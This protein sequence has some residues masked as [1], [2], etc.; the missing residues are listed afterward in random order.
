MRK[1]NKLFKS[2]V[3]CMATFILLALFIVPQLASAVYNAFLSISLTSST[4]SQNYGWC[5][6]DGVDKKVT[7]MQDVEFDA[8][9]GMDFSSGSWTLD[10]NGKLI[11]GGPAILVDDEAS[12]TIVGDGTILGNTYVSGDRI[13]KPGIYIMGGTVTIKGGNIVVKSGSLSGDDNYS[14]AIQMFRGTLNIESG[15]LTLHGAECGIY[16]YSGTVNISGGDLALKSGAAGIYASGYN[17]GS[18]TV[19]ISGG[20]LALESALGFDMF[21]TMVTISGGNVTLDSTQTSFD[22]GALTMTGGSLSVPDTPDVTLTH[23]GGA[24]YYRADGTVSAS[25]LAEDYTIP[26]NATLTVAEGEILT[27][28]DGAALTV[29]EGGTLINNGRIDCNGGATVVNNGTVTDTGTV[30]VDGVAHTHVLTRRYRDLLDGTH[31]VVDDCIDC[32]IGYVK[33]A[34]EIHDYL[35][36]AA[37]GACI[38][39]TCSK[40]NMI[41]ELRVEGTDVFT[42]DGI[43]HGAVAIGVPVNPAASLSIHYQTSQMDDLRDVAPT[44]VG[45]Y[46]AGLLLNVNGET[47]CQSK[48]FDFVIEPKQLVATGICVYEK[49]YDGNQIID[50]DYVAWEG[51]VDG[52]EVTVTAESAKVASADVGEY[53]QVTA[54]GLALSGTDA[55]NYTIT[56]TATL[57]VFNYW[58]APAMVSIYPASVHINALE[59]SVALNGLL[60]QTKWTVDEYSELV[61]GHYVASVTVTGDTSAATDFGTVMPADAVILDKAGN[62]M[63]KNYDVRYYGARL[64]VVCPDHDTFKNG[65][66]TYCGGNEMPVVDPGEDAEWTYDDTYLVSNA[67]QLFWI[68]DYVN[69]VS[70]ELNVK[71]MDDIVVPEGKAWTPIMNFY[72]NFDG[73]FKTVSGLYVKSTDEQVGMFGG[74]GYCY[75]T[76]KNL[77]LT[78]SYFEGS[79]YVGGLAGH[80]AGPVENCYVTDSVTVVGD[81]FVG[82]L[83]GD[84]ISTMSNCY[85]YA[86]TLVGYYNSSYATITNCYY[87]SEAETEDGGKTA[88]QF[89]SGEIAYLL[90]SN[91]LGEEVYDEET[92]S[93]ITLDPEHIWGQNIDTDAY[94][95]LGGKK[96]Y[97]VTN[98]KDEIAY[99]NTNSSGH[100]WTN[101]TCTAPKTCT[102]CGATEGEELGHS[103]ANGIC[104]TCGEADPDYVKP[105]VQPT[106]TLKAPTLE[107]KDMIKIVTF[108][109]AENLEDVVEMGMITYSSKVSTWNVETAE[110]VIPGYDYDAGSGR[111]ISSSQGIH[112]KY[113]S[114]DV[115]LA[116]YAKLSD[117]SYTYTR[118]VPY[119]PIT[120][121]T[122]QLNNSTNNTLKQLVVAMLNYGAAAQ[123]YFNQN[124]DNLANS[125]MTA[126]QLALP[127]SYRSDMVQSVPAPTKAKQGEFANNKGFSKRSPAVSFEGAF[128]IN[129]F[130]TP[131]YAPVGDITFYY[132]NEADYN[133]ATVLTAAN[134]SGSLIMDGEGMGQYHGDIVGIAAKDL[135]KAVY[136]AAVYTDGTNTWTSGVL[137]YSIGAYCASLAT[138][139]DAMADLAMATAVYGYHAKQ[140][141]G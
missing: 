114:E 7:L 11:Q 100:I 130:F 71:L 14:S 48:A 56:N 63:T 28:T 84:F 112:A 64:C 108:Y 109:T 92:G 30:Y 135:S 58:G 40:C 136:V 22:G 19:N 128:S 141:F 18:G 104:G 26:A 4:V 36:N 138:G 103:F 89:A 79:N 50:V 41:N 82:A 129:Y 113:L 101:A 39:E 111:Y 49:Y 3:L 25:N 137:G 55:G 65:F 121:A 83:V 46:R 10:L 139:T 45:K 85:A 107:F 134:A 38:H 131:A 70:N 47:V 94:P 59:Q 68:A 69:N 76:I 132:W 133:A 90:Q 125:T 42:Y 51:V 15:N 110:H 105:V 21:S 44:D 32:P 116:I 96:V 122:N 9:R 74:G 43:A 98:C 33:V 60:D 126:E 115:Y 34:V 31:Q 20:N 2:A 66:C 87:L 106:L 75:G 91:V 118:L 67:G 93:Y 12:L 97:Q 88:A 23:T 35:Y 95:V 99:S 27:L 62:D 123:V 53:A 81:D 52:D 17:D 6:V 117:G 86:S 29:A 24:I 37:E 102:T 54:L 61:A 124:L 78:N 16:N 77:G 8:G 57:N 120:Y 140:Y 119:S 13:Y 72:G 127:E 1:H 73:N 80:H 5:T